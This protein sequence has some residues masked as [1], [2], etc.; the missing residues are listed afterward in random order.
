MLPQNRRS[1]AFVGGIIASGFVF[2]AVVIHSGSLR[3]A[4]EDEPVEEPKD[5]YMTAFPPGGRKGVGKNINFERLSFRH[6][7]SFET[8]PAFRF[9]DPVLNKYNKFRFVLPCVKKGNCPSPE[10]E[11]YLDWKE[12]KQVQREKKLSCHLFPDCNRQRGPGFTTC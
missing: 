11:K 9:G 10:D 12:L 8:G 2:C 7:H 3:V 4:L 6:E 5:Y 1:V